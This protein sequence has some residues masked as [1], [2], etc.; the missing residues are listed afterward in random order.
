MPRKL[1]AWI[2]GVAGTLAA[3]ALAA[4][5]MLVGGDRRMLLSGDATDAHHQIELAC[6]TCHA[7]PPFASASAATRALNETCRN[8][9][10]DELRAADDSHS[11]KLFRS[12]RMA[13]YLEKLNV[14]LCT[15]C[16]IEHR[17][18]ITRTGAVTATA[19]FCAACHAEGDQDVRKARPS[20]AGLAFDSCASAGCHNYHDNRALYEDFLVRHAGR[21]WIAPTPVHGL[22]AG[23]RSPQQR[24][25]ALAQ[26]A[27]WAPA[28][29]LADP[30]AL[31]D[32]AG[33]AHAAAGV[34]CAACHAPAAAQGASRAAVEAQWINA[35]DTAI[36]KDCHQAQGKAFVQGRHGMRQHPL[37]AP[38]RNP[39]HGLQAI[40]IKGLLPK[41]AT[42]WLADPPRPAHMT[43]AE[44][45][46]P[47]RTETAAEALHCGSCHKPHAADTKR[48]AVE[49][50]ASCHDD[51]HSRAYFGGPHHELWRAE[52]AGEAPA[53]TGVSC[54]TCHMPKAERRDELATNHNQSATLRPI[55]KMIRPVCLDCHGL[56]FAIDA[57]AD[58]DLVARN[59]RGRPSIHVESVDWAVRRTLEAGN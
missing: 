3:T 46:L 38:P 10:D 54:A 50:C 59:F 27:A 53:G 18:E 21:P 4:I 7:A 37:L 17:P 52:L 39:D 32:W 14:R 31:H 56:G 12:P 9:H 29:A 6:E 44:A 49:A 48:A 2:L 1:L 30:A 45:R 5:W 11:R 23:S 58:A 25:E 42:A 19:D 33:S 16:H 15:T 13:V 22:A 41:A 36:C 35:P 8:C 26:S 43:V 20:H 55:E 28:A 40:G 51:A 24:Q 34:S 47:M 57:L